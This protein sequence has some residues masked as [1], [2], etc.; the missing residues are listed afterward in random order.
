MVGSHLR[1]RPSAGRETNKPAR[2]ERRVSIKSVD[3]TCKNGGPLKC[4]CMRR[5][6]HNNTTQ[7]VYYLLLLLS[8]HNNYKIYQKRGAIATKKPRRTL[9]DHCRDGFTAT[10]PL[11]RQRRLSRDDGQPKG[12]KSLRLRTGSLH[13]MTASIKRTRSRQIEKRRER[14]NAW[15][16]GWSFRPHYQPKNWGGGR[17]HRPVCGADY[18]SN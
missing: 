10:L 5:A 12:E 6:S 3:Q 13:R 8:S 7:Y 16:A 18:R 15:A 4:S 9:T 14:Q 1:L 11:P 17:T 2:R